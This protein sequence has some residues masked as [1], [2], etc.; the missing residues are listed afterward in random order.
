MTYN[1]CYNNKKTNKL[2]T[3]CCKSDSRN[4]LY[5]AIKF[6]TII[7]NLWMIIINIITELFTLIWLIIKKL[8]WLF[9]VE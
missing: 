3:C 8:L 2:K 5:R 6:T 7:I 9:F 1:L 4:E